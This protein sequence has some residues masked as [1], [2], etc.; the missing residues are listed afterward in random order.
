[1]SNDIGRTLAAGSWNLITGDDFKWSYEWVPDGENVEPFPSGAALYFEVGEEYDD[2]YRFDIAGGVAS[3]K[4]ESEVADL[5]EAQTPFRLVFQ[6]ED[7][8]PTDE[9]VIAFGRVKRLEPL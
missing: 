8:S 6:L 3:I 4:I 7:V 9:S 5:I 2:I 1:M